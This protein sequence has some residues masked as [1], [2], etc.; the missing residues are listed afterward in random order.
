MSTPAYQQQ[1][2]T[3]AA[4]NATG[5]QRAWMTVASR[6]IAVKLRDK[7]FILSTI[8]IIGVMAVSIGI[9]IFMSSRTSTE[10]IAV[11]DAQ[12]QQVVE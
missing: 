8:L 4:E 9:S 3:E 10:T 7:N 6:E 2:P 11:M 5:G 1:A 12:S